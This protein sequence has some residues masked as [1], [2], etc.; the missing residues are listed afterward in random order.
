V[1]GIVVV[2]T[3]RSQHRLAFIELLIYIVNGANFSGIFTFL[4][5]AQ[6]CRIA[7]YPVV[8]KANN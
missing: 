7:I 2:S 8:F 4:P 3:R 6:M 1:A 5:A